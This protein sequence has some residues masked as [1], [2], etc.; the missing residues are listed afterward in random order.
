VGKIKEGK[1]KKMDSMEVSRWYIGVILGQWGHSA[2]SLGKKA[3]GTN[4]RT[5]L[6]SLIQPT[7]ALLKVKEETHGFHQSRMLCTV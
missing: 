1:E 4:Y 6:C 3:I 7:S 5:Q 2:E